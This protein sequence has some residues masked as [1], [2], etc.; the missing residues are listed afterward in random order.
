MLKGLFLI[1]Q[2]QYSVGKNFIQEI[3]SDISTQGIKADLI[4]LSSQES[5][6]HHFKNKTDPE[7]YNF[8][9]SYNAVGLDI[10]FEEEKLNKFTERKPVFC[11]LVDHPIHNMQRFIGLKV[12]LLCVSEEHVNFAKQCGFAA[13]LFRHAVSLEK[14]PLL[15]EFEDFDI[16]EGIIFPASYISADDT[17][18]K[19]KPV[20]DKIN[21]II[22]NCNTITDFMGLL[23]V[24]PYQGQPAKLSLDSN[25]L[26]IC[27]L[28]DRYLR[29]KEREKLLAY[30]MKND[31]NLTVIG[32]S[33]FQYKENY[34]NHEYIDSINFEDLL[35]KIKKS[36]FIAH[37]SPGFQR[38]LHERVVYPMSL[39]TLISSCEDL[40]STIGDGYINIYPEDIN[41]INRSDYIELQMINFNLVYKNNTWQTQL[42]PIINKTI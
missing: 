18:L 3:I 7:S 24:I 21:P 42:L 22:N 5:I 25:I 32:R 17:I 33:V 29:A 20:W 34:P 26:N 8:I 1:G 35:K 10:V 4:D 38:G 15:N 11:F 36:R 14:K 12:T 41:I 27:I 30:F 16:K 2:N 6:S 13:H 31:I 23:G 37:H 19:L 39:G 9:L 28:V 40:T